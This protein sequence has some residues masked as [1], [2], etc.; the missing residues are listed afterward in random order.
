MDKKKEGNSPFDMI[1]ALGS[2]IIGL[3]IF[4]TIFGFLMYGMDSC[5]GKVL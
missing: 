2:S 4:L 1:K 3:I 5:A